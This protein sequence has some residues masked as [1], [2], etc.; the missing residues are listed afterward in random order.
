MDDVPASGSTAI[1]DIDL[2]QISPNP[3]QPRRT[4]DE[5]AL[6]ELASSIRELGIKA[7]REP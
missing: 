2:S 3:D 4:F 6:E 5:G 1:N 7:F